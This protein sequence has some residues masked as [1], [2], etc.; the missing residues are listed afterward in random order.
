MK[1]VALNAVI[2]LAI[3]KNSMERPTI[4][5]LGRDLRKSSSAYREVR[6]DKNTSTEEEEEK[7]VNAS[8]MVKTMNDFSFKKKGKPSL[9]LPPGTVNAAV[10][11]TVTMSAA[12]TMPN[13]AASFI[14]LSPSLT[15]SLCFSVKSSRGVFF[16]LL[17]SSLYLGITIFS[18]SCTETLCI[19]K[20][21]VLLN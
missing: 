1:R 16:S 2:M 19:D 15:K 5:F 18:T 3:D 12:T 11:A 10:N 14:H 6:I 9:L 20:T 21:C 8:A 17:R 4:I 13:D 7:S